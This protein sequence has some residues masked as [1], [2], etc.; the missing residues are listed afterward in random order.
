MKNSWI[1]S[2]LGAFVT[3]FYLVFLSACTTVG[4]EFEK[5]QVAVAPGWLQAGTEK[6]STDPA[7]YREWWKS[8]NDPVLSTLIERA[9]QNNLTLQIAGL[10]VYEARA[11]LGVATG[12]KFP[13]IQQLTGGA[14]KIWLSENAEPISYLPEDVLRA[15]DTD[16]GNY[17]VGFDAVWEMDFW[18]RYRRIEESADANFL[19]T[20]ATYDDVLVTVTAEVAAGYIQG[21]YRQS[22]VMQI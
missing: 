21:E 4:P 10:R 7:T 18:G 20:I 12:A 2:R 5:P 11:I 9:Y 19:A 13:Q 17:R 15:V 22:W 16:F 6:V 8:F 14:G 3:G 1:I